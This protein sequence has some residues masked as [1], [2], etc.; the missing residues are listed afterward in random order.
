M[1][2]APDVPTRPRFAMGREDVRS[3]L[4]GGLSGGIASIPSNIAI[5]F[6]ALA[7]LGVD[8]QSNGIFISLLAAA[9]GGALFTSACRTTGLIAGGSTSF[10]LVIAGVLT[11]LMQGGTLQPGLTGYPAA[12]A[13]IGLLAL[14]TAL[15]A[16]ALAATGLGRLVILLP[17]PVVSGIRNG[18]ALLMI[19]L[20]LRAAVGVAWSG[21]MPHWSHPANV[22]VA[23]VTM[24]LMLR[25]IRR[26]RLVPAA[27]VAVLA[28][29]GVHA[30]LAYVLTQRGHADLLGPTLD[31]P[32][33]GLPQ[34]VRALLAGWAALPSLPFGSLAVILLPAALTIALIGTLETL[35]G[36][37]V[38]QDTSGDHASSRSDMVALV[39]AN[40]GTGLCGILP[41]AGG[42]IASMVVWN[43]GGRSK[44][45]GLV[46]SATLLVTVL[47]AAPVVGFL[48]TAALAGLVVSNGLQIF[49]LEVLRLA[50]IAVS[51]GVEGR[52]EMLG[53]L[54][55]AAVV[56]VLA[57]TVSLVAAVLT[58]FLLSAVLFVGAMSGRAVRRR[59]HNVGSRSRTS[60]PEAETEAL[61]RY[62]NEI[63][64]IELQG[65]LFFG[66]V[67][68]LVREVETAWVAGARCVVLDVARV[69][70]ID[71]S[72][73]RRILQLANRHWRA[74]R[75]LAIASLGPASPVRR[76]YGAVGLLP[77]LRA[78]RVFPTLAAA[79]AE[80]ELAVLA[81][82]DV[83]RTET[84]AAGDILSRLGLP[85]TAVVT[86]LRDSSERVFAPGDVILRIGEL[87]DTLF[88]LLAGEVEIA[89]T[90]NG[91][92]SRLATLT[93]G[94]IFGEMALVSG[95][96]RSADVLALTPVRCIGLDIVTIERYRRTEPEVAYLLMAAIA[97]QLASNLLMANV[98]LGTD[99]E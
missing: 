34:H 27:L 25:P 69:S 50:R 65:A 89:L 71:L 43:A 52:S 11:V 6:I 77:Q 23:G 1:P 33:G 76:Y 18:A 66:S 2:T 68:Q 62:G 75:F 37:S 56:I 67:D 40:I 47:L 91:A 51:P 19:L 85:A 32:A 55:V 64:V 92:Q 3:D 15:C 45:A 42:S 8:A 96:P 28:G 60:R 53:N 24:A 7:P 63:E 95:A 80:A 30:L 41:V 12:L 14:L 54:F 73:A 83:P 88:I 61:L 31:P 78:D 17:Y 20:Q 87:A 90:I 97:S 36:A 46:R 16:A 29:A 35:V 74:G 22:A 84:V 81:A 58:G 4:I 39:A 98:A 99:V 59:Y 21:G 9:I 94:T 82:H 72:G 48:P 10:A 49:D 38:M 86:L 79:L 13:I 26:F 93:A 70:Q 44:L 5:G 57:M